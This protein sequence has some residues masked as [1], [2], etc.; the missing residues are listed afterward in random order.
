MAERKL[1]SADSHVNEPPT[2]WL[3]RL[4]V[5]FREDAPYV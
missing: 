4:Y 3:D 5:R 2:L 1:V